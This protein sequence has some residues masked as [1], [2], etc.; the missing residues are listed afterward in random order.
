LILGDTLP[1]EDVLKS[2]I[3]IAVGSIPESGGPFRAIVRIARYLREERFNTFLINIGPFASD[4]EELQDFI[5]IRSIKD[6][7][8]GVSFRLLSPRIISIIKS[9]DIIVVHGF[10]LLSTL[11]VLLIKR[12]HQRILVMPHGSLVKHYSN[13]GGIKKRIFRLVFSKLSALNK[14]QKNTEFICAKEVE[15]DEIKHYYPNHPIHVVGLGVDVAEIENLA[16]KSSK[17]SEIPQG[18]P[19]FIFV[20]RIHPVKNLENLL[21]MISEMKSIWPNLS[22]TVVGD[23][24]ISYKTRIFDLVSELGID[25]SVTF[26][27]FAHYDEIMPM[28]RFADCL[29]LA[30]HQENFA[31]VVA[32]SIAAGTPVVVSPFVGMSDFV[33]QYGTGVVVTDCSTQSL[34]LG[35]NNLIKDLEFYREACLRNRHLLDWKYSLDNWKLVLDQ[36]TSS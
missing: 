7:K 18:K 25:E 13:K 26:V 20:G 11:F 12:E 9:A 36:E 2:V 31:F 19:R 15:R 29:I 4:L 27:G 33:R 1:E 3:Q 5:S 22:L 16:S 34:C 24:D 30:S 10:Y 6:N 21:I 32:E 8:Y 14:N 23:G 17:S 28:I 35:V